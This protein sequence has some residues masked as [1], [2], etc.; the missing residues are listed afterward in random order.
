MSIFISL[1]ILQ[2]FRLPILHSITITINSIILLLLLLILIIHSNQDYGLKNKFIN[3]GKA[4]TNSKHLF[5]ILCI[6]FLSISI[7]G[8]INILISIIMCLIFLFLTA[9]YIKGKND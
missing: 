3:L 4:I 1:N 5:L 2:Y 8:G 6:Y 9:K 7:G